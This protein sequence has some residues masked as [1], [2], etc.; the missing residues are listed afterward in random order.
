MKL[1]F[2][3]FSITPHTNTCTDGVSQPAKSPNG[4]L[5]SPDVPRLV[6]CPRFI[7]CVDSILPIEKTPSVLEMEHCV[8]YMI[9]QYIIVYSVLLEFNLFSVLGEKNKN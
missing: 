5:V 8:F 7:Q 3:L 6:A 1:S 2:S 9:K 4:I